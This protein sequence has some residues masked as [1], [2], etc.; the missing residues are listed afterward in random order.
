[1]RGRA[2]RPGAIVLQQLEGGLLGAEASGGD[3]QLDRGDGDR[4]GAEGGGPEQPRRDQQEEQP[5]GQPDEEAGG[6][7]LSA[8]YAIFKQ[9]S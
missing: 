7:R 9:P 5:G 3:D 8:V 6:A 1:M 4:E 2:F